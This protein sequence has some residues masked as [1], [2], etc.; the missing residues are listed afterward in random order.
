MVANE[1]KELAKETAKATKDISQ[2]VHSIQQDAAG[3]VS[4]IKKITNV[5]G[6]INYIQNTLDRLVGRF[7][8]G[9]V[10][11]PPRPRHRPRREM[12]GVREK[13]IPSP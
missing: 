7:V 5:V 12:I 13:E 8:L 1:V 3:T 6:R 2:R 11:T 10:A 4:A 9:H